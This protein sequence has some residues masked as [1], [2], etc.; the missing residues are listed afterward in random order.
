[1]TVAE[2]GEFWS[3]QNFDLRLPNEGGK[4]WL[5]NCDGCFL[6]SEWSN[7]QLI[8]LHA[9]RAKWWERMEERISARRGRPT[10]FSTRGESRRALR[11]FVERQPDMLLDLPADESPLCGAESGDCTG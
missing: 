5:G 8:R 10:T 9:D 7:A 11:E 6:K 3:R 2:V 1:M 4:N